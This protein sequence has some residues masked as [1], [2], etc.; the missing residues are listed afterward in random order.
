MIGLF[1]SI[2]ASRDDE[3][4]SL[5]ASIGF[6]LSLN[7]EFPRG[8]DDYNT[9]AV[10]SFRYCLV[11]DDSIDQRD[12]VGKGLTA[13]SAGF[14]DRVNAIDQRLIGFDLDL[15]ELRHS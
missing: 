7:T 3:R 5:Q 1:S 4:A 2:K 9:S 8:T 10:F 15:S 11:P 14:N 6:L 13:S 12:E